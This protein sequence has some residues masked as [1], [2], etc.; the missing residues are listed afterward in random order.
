MADD[1]VFM[2]VIGNV[3]QPP[4]RSDRNDSFIKFS[5]AQNDGYGDDAGTEWFNITIN[6]D[7][8]PHLAGF[9]LDQLKK[10]SKGVYVEG[11]GTIKEV[12][13]KTYR[14]MWA[15][16]IGLVEFVTAESAPKQAT[17]EDDY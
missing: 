13:G 5:V 14:D 15:S 17:D 6:E 10:G 2:R 8:K 3:G 1:S 11:Y 7:K 9:A 12:N 4:E 16:R